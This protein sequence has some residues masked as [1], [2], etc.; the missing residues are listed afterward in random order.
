MQ[1]EDMRYIFGYGVIVLSYTALVYSKMLRKNMKGF[2]FMST[3]TGK[4]FV[5]SNKTGSAKSY[6]NNSITSIWLST[7]GK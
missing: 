7:K 3:L 4:A 5:N 2:T 6:V 1:S